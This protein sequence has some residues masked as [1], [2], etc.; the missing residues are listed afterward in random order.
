MNRFARVLNG[1]VKSLVTLYCGYTYCFASSHS[2]LFPSNTTL[3]VHCENFGD[4]RK[5]LRN[6]NFE[7]LLQERLLS[8]A[9]NSMKGWLKVHYDSFFE[10]RGLYLDEILE[11]ELGAITYA[12]VPHEDEYLP[13]FVASFE[14][15]D[16]L[17]VNIVLEQF[18][19]RAQDYNANVASVNQEGIVITEVSFKGR[20]VAYSMVNQNLVLGTSI[21]AVSDLKDKI[22]ELSGSSQVD[23]LEKNLVFKKLCTNSVEQQIPNLKAY[24]Q[25]RSELISSL[26]SLPSIFSPIRNSL[27]KLLRDQSFSVFIGLPN[28]PAKII[29]QFTSHSAKP[30]TQYHVLGGQFPRTPII[31]EDVSTHTTFHIRLDQVLFSLASTQYSN[32]EVADST[33]MKLIESSLNQYLI[34]RIDFMTYDDGSFIARVPLI[35]PDSTIPRIEAMIEDKVSSGLLNKSKHVDKIVYTLKSGVPRGSDAIQL[36]LYFGSDAIYIGSIEGLLRPD[37]G[38]DESLA[39]Y[40]DDLV[41]T[42]LGEAMSGEVLMRQQFNL[43]LIF[44]RLKAWKAASGNTTAISMESKRSFTELLDGLR[45]GLGECGASLRETDGGLQYTLVIRVK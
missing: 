8:G 24:F 41:G 11:L 20:T 45:N 10:G 44:D 18:A 14:N 32:G 13:Y 9:L 2:E 16:E 25:P 33:A 1:L 28:A 26:D 22:L 40:S 3:Y 38:D 12:V 35:R 7:R 6:G 29:A 17:D 43:N 39:D 42:L 19:R 34:N 21:L 27:S 37:I 4:F 5:T 31:S 36:G 15:G 23:T 30:R